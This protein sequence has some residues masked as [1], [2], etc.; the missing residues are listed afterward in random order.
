MFDANVDFENESINSTTD[1]DEP[2]DDEHTFPFKLHSV[3]EDATT[4]GLE[5]I[6]S[7]I[8]GGIAFKVHNH[9]AFVDKITPN[10]FDQTKYEYFRRQL[11]LY[12]FNR[13]SRGV[14]RGE[15]SHPLFVKSNRSVCRYIERQQNKNIIRC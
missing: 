7:W 1:Q 4:G 5:D 6:I 3:L 14:K 11:N 9:K 15:V 8:G 2:E 12:G 10:Y 13:V